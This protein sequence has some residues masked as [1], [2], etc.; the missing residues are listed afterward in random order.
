MSN[1]ALRELRESFTRPQESRESATKT[2]G[3]EQAIAELR[4]LYT[5]IK[6]PL[7]NAIQE[8]EYW[9]QRRW[10][11]DEELP[12]G[13]R[14]EGTD[15]GDAINDALHQTLGEVAQL[16]WLLG[17]YVEKD[18][19]DHTKAF[20]EY[21]KGVWSCRQPGCDCHLEEVHDYER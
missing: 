13:Q 20:M 15:T 7:E 4:I 1:D 9:F 12:P 8:Q 19:T 11:P 17:E 16:L 6:G 18:E 5:K 14:I 21:R 10:L 2:T 3:N